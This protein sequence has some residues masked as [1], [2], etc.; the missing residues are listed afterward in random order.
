MKTVDGLISEWSEEER[1][2]LKDLI[3]ECQEREK[4]LV[5]NSES[6]AKNLTKL[7]E[8]LNVFFTQTIEMKEKTEKVADDLLGLY[9]R[10]YKKKLPLS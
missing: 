2:K 9:L 7:T 8:S 10:M 4:Q 3:K 5:E 1:E 6:C